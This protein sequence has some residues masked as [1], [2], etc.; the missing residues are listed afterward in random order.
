MKTRDDILPLTNDYSAVTEMP[1]SGATREQLARLYH[2]YHTAR[3]YATHKRVLEVASGTGMGLSYL[4]HTASSVIGGDYTPNLL[5]IAHSH[6]Q[7]RMPLL[8][9]DAHH[10]PFHSHTFDLVIIFEA[11][12]YLPDAEEF[13]TEARRILDKDGTLLISTVNKDW[14]EFAPS[15]FSTRYFS[16]PELYD[17]LSQKDFIELEFYGAFPTKTA[18]FRQMAVSLVRR[19]AVVLNLMP[20][21]LT[22][23]ALLKQIFYG[24]LTPLPSEVSEDMATLYP[25]EPITTNLSN[26]KEYKIIYCTAQCP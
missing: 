1:G 9:L 3:Q 15:S 2:R 23:R 18:S 7:D 22:G 13:I 21:T 11:I 12:Y 4:A 8:C 17:L 16:V 26:N 5:H 20:K 10:L 25:L 6:Y 24:N 14:G 19:L